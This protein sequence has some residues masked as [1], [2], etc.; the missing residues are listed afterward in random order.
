MSLLDLLTG[1][2]SKA[3]T[4]GGLKISLPTK[5]MTMSLIT[6]NAIGLFVFYHLT[7]D[8]IQHPLPRSTGLTRL[9]DLFPAHCQ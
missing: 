1:T 3:A 7:S 6:W 2:V 5:L 8:T 9:M 4:D